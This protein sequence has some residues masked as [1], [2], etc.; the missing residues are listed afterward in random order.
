LAAIVESSTDAILSK[1]LDGVI[2]TWNRGAERLFGY[3]VP[4]IVGQP[5]SLLIPAD[6]AV[7]EERQVEALMRGEMVETF[8]TV[9][10]H[11]NGRRFDASVTLSTI[12]GAAGILTGV[13]SIVRDISERKRLEAEVLQASEQEQQ[14][15]SQDLHDGL[16][17]E[18]AG[19]SCLSNI[20][21]KELGKK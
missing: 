19:I 1:N 2:T 16:G 10:V 15:I 13:S 12:K 9:R 6:R 21:Q 7:E 14:R 20:L 18:L 3:S 4:E 17:Q 8:E 5:I 11:K